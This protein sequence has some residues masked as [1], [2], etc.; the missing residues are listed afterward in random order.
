MRIKRKRKMLEDQKVGIH[1]L[2]QKMWSGSE[3]V[4]M[5]DSCL[6]EDTTQNMN[7]HETL[8]GEVNEVN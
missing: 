2:V 1:A 5:I 4:D 3:T 7:K 8:N 6:R